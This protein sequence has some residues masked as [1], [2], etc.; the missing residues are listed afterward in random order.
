MMVVTI[1]RPA[2]L[3]IAAVLWFRLVRLWFDM[4]VNVNKEKEVPLLDYGN[5]RLSRQ[6]DR[7]GE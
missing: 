4:S 6:V 2:T 1:Y 3:S 7:I 5:S